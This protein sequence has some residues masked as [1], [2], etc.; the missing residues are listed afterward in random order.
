MKM[1][2][3]H[4]SR[5]LAIAKGLASDS[6]DI[7]PYAD[8]GFCG[9]PNH[10]EAIKILWERRCYAPVAIV[11]GL[12]GS[13]VDGL[14]ANLESAFEKTNHVERSWMENEGVKSLVAKARSTSVGDVIE[15]VLGAHSIFWRVDGVGFKFLAR[16]SSVGAKEGA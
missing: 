6:K 13:G 9:M 4:L 12:A 2:V 3:H 16:A 10:G 14:T 8:A 11:E 15:E 1:I 5:D 7:F